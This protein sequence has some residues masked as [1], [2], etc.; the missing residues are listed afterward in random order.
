[1]EPT[2][3]NHRIGV[4]DLIRGFALLGLP[5]VNI[6]LLWRNNMNL[7]GTTGDIWIQRFLYIFIEGRFY[8][9]FSFLFGLGLWIFLSRAKDKQE[10]TTVLFVRR[11]LI[12]LV[13]GI[14]HQFIHPG[15]ALLVYAILGF[16]MVFFYKMP[17]QL[18]VILGI[19]GVIV[20]SILG[21]KFLLPLPLMLLG[22]AFGQYRVFESY[23]KNRKKWMSVGIFSFIATTL[24]AIYLWQQAPDLG[25]TFFI[26]GQELTE[27]QMNANRAFY[28]YANQ[29]LLFAPFFSIFYVSCLVMLE[30][31]NRKLFS[32]L[33]AFG[34]MAFTNYIGQSIILILITLFM[35]TGTIVSYKFA[36]VTC[37][38]LVICQMIFSMYWLRYFK[39]G[40]L[41]WLWRCGTYGK[42]LSIK[43]S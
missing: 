12:L 28:D 29:A 38:L 39:Y 34:R 5:F 26:E 33:N 20:G 13:V 25:S 27:A 3:Q 7:S 40:P 37:L 42:M 21:A 32:P 18:N 17:K 15:E 11:M 31:T 16:L 35:P 19:I 23:Q 14:I 9:I 22:L 6:L 4:I 10:H 41:E 8:A 24:S 1:M 36:M 30:A 43:K 2:I